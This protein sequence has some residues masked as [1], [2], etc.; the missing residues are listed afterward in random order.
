M[1]QNKLSMNQSMIPILILAMAIMFIMAGCDTGQ[2]PDKSYKP[3]VI[4]PAY[5]AGEGPLVCLDEAHNNFHTLENRFWA[6]GELLRRDGYVVES[7]RKKFSA[8]VLERCLVLVIANAQLEG[9][10]WGEYPYPTPSGFTDEEIEAVQT[11]VNDGGSLLL[12]ADHMPL[13]GVASKLASAF[14]VEFNDGF[15]VAGFEDEASRDAAFGIPTIFSIDTQ[16]LLQH[17][18]TAGRRTSESVTSIRSFTGQAFQAPDSAQPL[19]VL[20]DDFVS[21]MPRKAWEFGPDTK[22][23]PVGGWLQGAVMPFGSGRAAFFGEAAMFT[24]QL[25]DNQPSGMN[26]PMAEQNFQFVLNVVHWLSR[27]L[28]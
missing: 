20:P 15:A 16:T 21:L 1:S 9:L 3:T 17:P 5:Q 22:T 28:N 14:G 10:D 24:A 7:S 12:I 19:M 23:I 27:I 8:S 2:V 6:F 13:A 4:D 11:W 25:T 26:A 18:I